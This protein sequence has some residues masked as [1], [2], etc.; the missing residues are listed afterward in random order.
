[1]AKKIFLA[2]LLAM[3]SLGINAQT[4]TKTDDGKYNVYCTVVGYNSFGFGKLKVILDMGYS[5]KNE[6]SLYGEDGK[7][8]KFN[9]MME[10]L[11]YMAKRGWKLVNTYYITMVGKQNVVNYV[12]E[13][14][15]SNDSEKTEGLTIKPEE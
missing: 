15:I 11:D 8:I 10:V 6:N 5:S 13:K 2:L 12:M 4:V 1:M 3:L 9:S 14:R 7:K